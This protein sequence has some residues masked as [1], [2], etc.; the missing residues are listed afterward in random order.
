M[1]NAYLNYKSKSLSNSAITI[2]DIRKANKVL[3]ALFTR[4]GD[5]IIDLVVINEFVENYPD[6]DYLVLCPKQMKPYC[7]EFAPK[8]KCI[9]V[10]KRNYLDMIKLDS[11]LKKWRPDLGFNPWSFG[12]ESNFFLTYSK[13]YQFY[14]NFKKPEIINHY[15]VVRK[16]LSLPEKNW[17][18]HDLKMELSY[19]QVLICPESTD[20]E[21]S[22]SNDEVDL[23]IN[24]FKSNYGS[25]LFTIASLS[26]SY[27]HSNWDSFIFKKTKKSSKDFIKLVKDSDLIICADSAPLHIAIAL[28]KNVIAVFNSTTPEIAI[29]SDS[30]VSLKL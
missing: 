30:E 24:K 2:E 10:N 29:N 12:A 7:E 27:L 9:G 17:K 13:K 23:I 20:N 15:E 14:N 3:F 25:P 11:Y 22:I 16:Y 4:Y 1:I 18:I 19:K 5:T 28:K 26:L 8:V 21:R 6:K